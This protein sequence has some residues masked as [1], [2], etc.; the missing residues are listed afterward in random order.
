VG[1]KLQIGDSVYMAV[2]HETYTLSTNAWANADP[3]SGF[4]KIT[5]IDPASVTKVNAA[6]MTK[7]ATGKYDYQYTIPA[8]SAGQW[9]G[10]VDAENENYPSRE[11]F[12][13]RVEA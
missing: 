13:F 10:Y 1:R 9:T 7:K 5:I 2:V 11:Y 6:S 12:S 8:A 4:P 3:D